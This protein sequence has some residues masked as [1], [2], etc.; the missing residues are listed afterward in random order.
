MG[1]FDSLFDAENH[2]WQT[3]AFDCNLDEYAI[4]DRIPADGAASYQVEVLSS[5]GVWPTR[6]FIHAFATIEHGILIAA[7]VERDNRLPLLDYSG[8]L[9]AGATEPR[10][11]RRG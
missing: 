1:M 4:G 3:K 9:T 10:G 8:R 2:E 5:T 7:G 11:D 6:E